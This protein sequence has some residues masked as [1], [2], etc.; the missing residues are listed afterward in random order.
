[1]GTVRLPKIPVLTIDDFVS[2]QL[3]AVGGSCFGL[4]LI[5]LGIAWTGSLPPAAGKGVSLIYSKLVFPMMVFR[6]VAAIKLGGVDTSLLSVMVLSKASMAAIVVLF[7]YLMLRH[8]HGPP[9]L[10][11]SLPPLAPSQSLG[12]LEYPPE[13]QRIP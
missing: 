4:M 11:T 6:G 13:H 5:G 9:A 7:G 2:A 8:S 10:L 3:F 12:V 1:M